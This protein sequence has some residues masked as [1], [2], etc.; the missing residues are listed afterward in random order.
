MDRRDGSPGGRAGSTSTPGRAMS[1]KLALE[2]ERPRVERV[3][4]MKACGKRG[5]V[6]G[7]ARTARTDRSPCLDGTDTGPARCRV[8]AV[9]TRPRRTPRAGAFT[10][11]TLEEP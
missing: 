4:M 5:S 9:P 7:S 3:R 6:L 2:P 11:P 8:R 10:F 1:E